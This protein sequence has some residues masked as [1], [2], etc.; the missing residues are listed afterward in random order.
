MEAKKAR[1]I[2]TRIAAERIS[3]LTVEVEELSFQLAKA[4]TDIA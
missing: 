2:T 4:Q 3:Q 1:D